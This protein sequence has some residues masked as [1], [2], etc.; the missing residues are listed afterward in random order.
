MAEHISELC[1][2]LVDDLYGELSSRVFSILA[3][4]GRL[5]IR[6]VVKYSDLTARDIKHGLAVLIQQ[7]LVL[8]YTTEEEIFYEPHWE[9]AY[10]L[11]RAGK[12]VKMV[13]DRFGESAGGLVSNLLLLGHARISDLADAYGVSFKAGGVDSESLHVN[14][15][16]IVNGDDASAGA[17]KRQIHIKT[18][19]DLHRILRQLLDA[20]FIIPV[21]RRHFHPTS[22]LRN[23]A[24]RIVKANVFGGQVKGKQVAEME[25]EVNKLL[26][27][28][29][30]E[31]EDEEVQ[32]GGASAGM[33][34][35]REDSNLQARKRV[36]VNARI[37]NGSSS[38]AA[39]NVIP[40]DDDL[41]VAVSQ[42]KCTVA[43]RTEQLVDY[44]SRYLGETT[45][46]VYEA[47]LRQME[48]KVHRCNDPFDQA[49]SEEDEADSLPSV[50][51][52]ELLDILD[53]DLDLTD[54]VRNQDAQTNGDALSDDE[55]DTS[56]TNGT[57][58]TNGTGPVAPLGRLDLVKLHCSLL[59]EDPRRFVRWVGKGGGGEYKVDF[60]PLTLSLIQHEL[61]ATVLARWGPLAARIIRILHAKGKL[62][63]KQV[64]T[65]GLM[66]TK[67]IRAALTAM[68][69]ANFVETQEVP[70]DNTRA[71]S[72][73]MYFWFF[74]QE[75]CRQLVLTD[76]YK[77]M[78]R[79]LQRIKV[80]R[81]KVQSV[82]DK[83]ERSDVVG[84]EDRFLTETERRAL[85]TWRE[86]EE[87]LLVQLERQDNL[88]AILRD[89]KMPPI[90][91]SS[92]NDL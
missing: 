41:V 85:R 27:K 60:R 24:E 2:L 62:D 68:Q 70:K 28:W 51:A 57:A 54:G 4:L 15:N 3:K 77:A 35:G 10:A 55:E 73:T 32:T 36:K 64:S 75:R 29:R 92:W 9:Q 18:L 26:K 82:I 25:V 90:P 8:H 87:K 37:P 67:E 61:E 86:G 23:E 63:E 16:G 74:D 20:G 47:L 5:T 66:R 7:N 65:T 43:L 13:E 11:V 6:G 56:M 59:F 58:R 78:A 21:R 89:F 80:E 46:K 50:T 72:R 79:I 22:D 34:R 14:G 33:K 1:T 69:E 39:A 12:I 76:T 40:L 42:D 44:A 30:D 52:R 91:K 49:P 84:H 38:A 88:V 17:D 19:D 31:E 48:K 53:P 45:S 83:A 81:A 71:P